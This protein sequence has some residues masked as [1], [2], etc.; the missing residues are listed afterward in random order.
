MQLGLAV[1]TQDDAG[2]YQTR[3]CP[4][5]SWAEHGHARQ[6]PHEYQRDGTAKLLT[7]FFPNS[8]EVSQTL[9]QIITALEATVTGRDRAPTPFQ[10]GW[11][12]PRPSQAQPTTATFIGRLRRMYPGSGPATQDTRS[13]TT[14]ISIRLPSDPLVRSWLSQIS[15]A[16]LTLDSLGW[17]LPSAV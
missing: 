17:V 15:L 5:Q 9:Q 10:C 3:P 16:M 2:P 14:L 4:G 12:A 13:P 6:P 11:Q 7:L 1:W 8:G